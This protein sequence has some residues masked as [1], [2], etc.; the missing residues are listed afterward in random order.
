MAQRI[1]S[2]PMLSGAL[3]SR[4]A[5]AALLLMAC[6]ALTGCGLMA[7]A[8]D[9]GTAGTD[10]AAAKVSEESMRGEPIPYN[11]SFS[12]RGKG[13]EDLES[14]MHS[15]SQLVELEKDPPDSLL[16]VERRARADVETALNLLHSQ[17]YYDGEA[18]YSINDNANPVEVSLVLTPGPR[19]VLGR[20]AIHYH[21]DPRIPDFFMNRHIRSGFFNSAVRKVPGPEFPGSLPGVEPGLPIV[22]DDM[23]EAVKALPEKF[24]ERGYPQAH[25][26]EA[27]YTLD[28]KTRTLNADVIVD[29]GPPALMGPVVVSG[30]KDINPS[31]IQRLA[32]WKVGERPW[33]SAM[34]ENYANMLRGLGLFRTVETRPFT[35]GKSK[36]IKDGQ[37]IE[38]LPVELSVEE[39]LMRSVGA[40]LRYDTDTGFGANLTWEHK[41]LFHNGEKLKVDAPISLEETGIK[42]A[43]EKPAFLFRQQRLLANASLLMENTDAYKQTSM[44][45]ELG[46]DRHVWRYWSGG[47]GVYAEAGYLEDS[48]HKDNSYWMFSPR[49]HLRFDSRNDKLNP[50]RGN[51]SELK[52]KPFGGSYNESFSAFAGTLSSSFYYSPLPYKNGRPDDSLVLAARI[53]GGWMLGSPLEHIPASLR[54]FAGGAGSVRG[55]PYQAIGPRNKDDDPLGGRSFQVVNLE[56]RFRFADNF[57]IVPFIDGG[58]VYKEEFPKIIGD[59]DWGAGLGFRYYTPIG[60][61]RLDLATPLNYI[62]DDPPVQLY[63]SIGQSF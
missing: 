58:M 36:I 12:V 30:A 41:N 51:E 57:G 18:S 26:T 60:P 35:S 5:Q 62:K 63:I 34:L 59:M 31:Y 37:E 40:A 17:C 11:V 20:A 21:P 1:H 39:G 16:A 6:L 44:R 2:R 45:G 4:L 19:Y 43:F 52:I 42:A 47:I 61:V 13:G 9:K 38:V 54:Y 8:R 55:Y 3:L 50:S 25:V 24:R 10:A 15:L 48:D 28:K 53:E 29:P 7:A 32:P 46:M 33:N 49:A 22:A 23:L 14:K 56:A 27:I